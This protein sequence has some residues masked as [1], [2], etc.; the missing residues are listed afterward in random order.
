MLVEAEN[1]GACRVGTG[2]ADGAGTGVVLGGLGGV[3]ERAMRA[4]L[5]GSGAGTGYAG[6]FP[7]RAVAGRGLSGGTGIVELVV[8]H[9][10]N[11]VGG[12]LPINK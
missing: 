3:L 1:V 6:P 11:G 9:E 2:Y 8:V 4:V 7:V 12:S 10:I 5:D